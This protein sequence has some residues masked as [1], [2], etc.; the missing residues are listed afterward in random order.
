MKKFVAFV[1]AMVMVFSLAMT[2]A[3]RQ[4]VNARSTSELHI[5]PS[6]L[7]SARMG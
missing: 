7:P 4:I 6:R 1:L 3:A 2:V 5:T